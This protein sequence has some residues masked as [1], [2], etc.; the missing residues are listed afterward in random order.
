M[1]IATI[2]CKFRSKSDWNVPT[3]CIQR[4]YDCSVHGFY[5]DADMSEDF[6]QF[7]QNFR[8]K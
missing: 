8:I 2:K 6:H 4:A 5:S 3:V 1:T 7:S